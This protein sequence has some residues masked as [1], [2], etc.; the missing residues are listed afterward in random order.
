MLFTVVACKSK[1]FPSR[2]TCF[3]WNTP[4]FSIHLVRQFNGMNFHLGEV[5]IFLFKRKKHGHIFKIIF[6][7][8]HDEYV[9]AW[10]PRDCSVF[11]CNYF[12]LLHSDQDTPWSRDW[13]SSLQIKFSIK[14]LGSR[15][16]EKTL[17]T[18]SEPPVGVARTGIG[19]GSREDKSISVG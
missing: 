4:V 9:R 18:K 12:L 8:R 17:E 11:H 14:F 1:C 15:D 10:I 13:N 2:S 3:R 16:K 19:E 6:A 7:S 5:V